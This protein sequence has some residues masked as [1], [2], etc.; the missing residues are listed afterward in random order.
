MTLTFILQVTFL[1]DR[2]DH[3]HVKRNPPVNTET[4]T[5]GQIPILK[6][7]AF[8]E[9]Y[10]SGSSVNAKPSKKRKLILNT[11]ETDDSDDQGPQSGEKK[12]I[13]NPPLVEKAPSQ[14]IVR[15]ISIL[16]LSVD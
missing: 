15:T 12:L 10:A 1:E 2:A 16:L 3:V 9:L 5:R 7:R 13:K 4:T 14:N 8:G 11:P 6:T